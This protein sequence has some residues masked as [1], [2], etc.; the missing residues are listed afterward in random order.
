MTAAYEFHGHAIVSDDDKIA[1]PDGTMPASLTNAADW[2][3]FQR[4]LGRAAVVALGRKGHESHQNLHKRNRL[5]LS[6]SARGIEQRDGAWWWNPA[7]VPLAE[8]LAAAAPAGGIV[9]IPGGQRVFDYFLEHGYDEFHLARARGVRLH[10]GVPV[11]SEC[12]ANRSAEEVLTARGLVPYPVDILD[13]WAGVS[14]T[15]WQKQRRK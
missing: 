1:A 4:E 8:A 13:A 2:A 7:D 9:A 5:V 14:V 15:V 3:R 11:F 6:S 10:D 12:S